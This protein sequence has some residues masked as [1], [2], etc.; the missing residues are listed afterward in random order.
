MDRCI[1]VLDRLFDAGVPTGKK[2][3]PM[4][5]FPGSVDVGYRYKGSYRKQSSFGRAPDMR[6]DHNPHSTHSVDITFSARK[7]G[8]TLHNPRVILKS[9]LDH[10][11]N[12]CLF[13]FTQSL[14]AVDVAESAAVDMAML[15]RRWRLI[16][17]GRDATITKRMDTHGGHKK[18]FVNAVGRFS[19]PHSADDSPKTME[20]LSS[21]RLHA[22]SSRWIKGVPQ[23]I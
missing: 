6:G 8:T 18:S 23:R 20:G 1:D 10:K 15:D 2:Q 4:T 22:G 7:N 19:Q 17:T 3:P 5:D 21:P 11:L 9:S 13:R 14:D 16:G 12:A